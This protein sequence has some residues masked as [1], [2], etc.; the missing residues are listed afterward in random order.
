MESRQ[1]PRHGIC[2]C[3]DEATRIWSLESSPAKGDVLE[4]LHGDGQDDDNDRRVED[5]RL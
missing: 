1:R 4:F 2:D 5:P 3:I